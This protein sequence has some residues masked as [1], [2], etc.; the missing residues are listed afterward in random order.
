MPRNNRRR[1]NRRARRRNV[2]TQQILL[3]Q[4]IG[5]TEFRLVDIFYNAVDDTQDIN[6]DLFTLLSSSNDY[7]DLQENFGEM[8]FQFLKVKG[9]PRHKY[10]TTLT[11]YALGAVAIRQGPYN[12][13]STYNVNQV[14][15]MPGSL[16]INNFDNFQLPEMKIQQK[17]FLPSNLT[18]S[19]STSLPKLN[20][21]FGWQTNAST[22]TGNLCLHL[23]LG[24]RVKSRI[25]F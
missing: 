20:I 3:D 8:Q 11:D 21:F 24:V 10:S 13:I 15:A 2:H 17:Q 14:I 18:N 16:L 4:Q 6:I 9:V 1:N 23:Q 25:N 12:V 5:K 7:A 19:T 22:N